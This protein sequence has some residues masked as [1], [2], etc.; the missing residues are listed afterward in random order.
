MPP[1]E[2]GGELQNLVSNS[3]SPTV[4]AAYLDVPLGRLIRTF[5]DPL[6]DLRVEQKLLASPLQHPAALTIA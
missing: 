5:D 4:P 6:P 2:Q 1:P 3:D